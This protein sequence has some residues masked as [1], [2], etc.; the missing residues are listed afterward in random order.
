MHLFADDMIIYT[1]G[2]NTDDIIQTLQSIF[3]QVHEKEQAQVLIK[4]PVV[5][6]IGLQIL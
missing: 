2:E 5:F 6:R 3:N 4:P 1:L